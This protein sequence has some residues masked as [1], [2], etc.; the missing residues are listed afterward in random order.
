MRRTAGD[1]AS[2]FHVP[3]RFQRSVQLERDFYDPRALDDYIP[4][5][6]MIDAFQ[7]IAAGLCPSSGHR[8]WRI[9]GDY[10]VGK[11]SFALVLAHL[12]RHPNSPAV[13]RLAEAM[14]WQGCGEATAVFWPILI[15]GAQENIVRAVARGILDG[16]E[17]AGLSRTRD[18]IRLAQ[19]AIADG[20]LRPLEELITTLRMAAAA[21]G[22]GVLLII[23]ELGK[24]L[25]YAATQPNPQDVFALQRIA[26]FATRSGEHPL[27]FVG[28]LHQAFSSY[29]ARLP[30]STR[31]EW[32][33]IAG[34]FEEIV[35]DQPL[36]HTAALVAGALGVDVQD[37]PQPVLRAARAA[38]DA[39]AR[40]GWLSGGTSG[41]VVLDASAIYPIHPTLLPPLTRF[42][43]RFGQHE[44]SLFGFLLSG[45][46]G[47]LQGFARRPLS[48]G[49]W[50]GIPEFFDYVRAAYG[51]RLAGDSYRNHWLRIAAAAGQTDELSDLERRVLKAIAVLNLLDAEDLLPTESAIGAALTPTPIKQVQ[52]ALVTLV[53]R[54]VLHCRGAKGGFR[55]WPNTSINL[56]TALEQ[57][58][59]A[60]EAIE[61][62]SASLLPYLR[63]EPVLARRH[64]IEEGTLRYFEVRYALPDGLLAA[65]EKPT[66]AD[67]LIIIALA[68][69]ETARRQALGAAIQSPFSEQKSLLI[70]IGHP[71]GDLHAELLDLKRWV[72]IREHTPELAHDPY[73]A[74]EVTRQIASARSALNYK[75]EQRSGLSSTSEA[76]TWI[77]SGSEQHFA[78]GLTAGLSRICNELYPSA[79]RIFNELLNRNTLSSAAA[80]ARMRLIERLF[81]SADKSSLGIDDTKAPPERSMYLSV[82]KAGR[83]HIEERNG[84]WRLAFPRASN[85][86]L[87]LI[88]ALDEIVRIIADGRGARVP[89]PAILIS[90]KQPPF[91]VR[92]GVAPLLLAFVLCVRSHEYAVYEDGTFLHQFG[93]ADFLR[94]TK[95]PGAFDV[96]HCQIEGV[97]AEV[98]ELLAEAFAEGIQGRRADLL[99]VVTPL[100]QFAAR[101]PE[102]TLKAG[103]LTTVAAAVRNTLLSSREPAQMLFTELPVACG[104][105]AFNPDEPADRRQANDFVG[106]LKAAITELKD[107]YPRLVDR[108]INR[109][110]IALGEE[111]SRFDRA[112]LA[113]RAARVSLAARELR[114]RGLALQL[115]DVG[116]NDRAWA[117]NLGS[118]VL[119]RPPKKWE[120]DDEARFQQEFGLLAEVFNKVEAAA[121][122]DGDDRPATDAVRLN[123]TR[124]DGKD[125]IMVVHPT[126][127]DDQDQKQLSLLRERL[128]Q[129]APLRVKFLTQLLWEEMTTQASP[130]LESE[131]RGQARRKGR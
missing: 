96:Q 94:L 28:I 18:L 66:G 110:A 95:S 2:L 7:R 30:T 42:F 75:L 25:E 112:G 5:P 15:T 38:A 87:A 85:D 50:Y 115:R 113:N 121:F 93:P 65:V 22:S 111:P 12:L 31:L 46:P 13:R 122:S 37:L 17:Q 76:I 14:D 40:M 6:T 118:F 79:P 128:P 36:V 29:A 55:L 41:A 72:W 116:L 34:R 105:N 60:V 27:L 69:T 80:A 90:L 127:L 83:L 81:T 109:V 20:G 52:A 106:S 108:V 21:E 82:M 3:K 48:D 67:G 59:R 8:A 39:T 102:Y 103:A 10:G 53:D 92:D 33:K 43:A 61:N 130:V 35:F 74:E 1:I 124:G 71:L 88:P 99:D 70:G 84:T 104:F 117:E 26:E 51:H 11:S 4:T 54:G 119:S 78:S 126:Q 16:I 100:C 49:A 114:L 68:D 77:R 44:R 73:A 32:E 57:A 89:V 86:P 101:L 91:G 45:E 63:R 131:T 120:V 9:T 125:A 58:T 107:A 97:R 129:G 98:F 56:H 24:L 62:V 123:L 47:G 64:Y 19:T 23:D